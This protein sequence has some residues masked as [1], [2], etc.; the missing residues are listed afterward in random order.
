V[1]AVASRIP[2]TVH[3]ADGALPLVP[4]EDAAAFAAAAAVLLADPAAWR[5]ARRAGT[6][7]AR[8]YAPAA[9]APLLDR[10]VRWA[11]A[12]NRRDGRSP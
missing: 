2:S 5:R 7:R 12:V 11:A 9:V 4:P 8:A 1:P 10:A 3:L 6:E